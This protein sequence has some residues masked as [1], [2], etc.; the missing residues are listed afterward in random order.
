MLASWAS[1]HRITELQGLEGA[2][3]YQVQPPVIAET[4]QQVVQV[5][6]QMGLEYLHR[7]K[8]HH[9]SVQPV[10]VLCHPY[11]KEVLPQICVEFPVFQLLAITPFPTTT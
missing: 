9:L 3:R 1:V 6:I 2:S 7:R 10:P 4:L 8:L 11:H 5:D